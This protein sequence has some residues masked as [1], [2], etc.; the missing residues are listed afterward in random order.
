MS[1]SSLFMALSNKV[2]RC[3]VDLLFLLTKQIAA[4]TRIMPTALA[5]QNHHDCHKGDGPG[6]NLPGSVM[7]WIGGVTGQG[8][9]G[10]KAQVLRLRVR[11]LNSRWRWGR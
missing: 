9:Y 10:I 8:I 6:R 5:S 11:S 2:L 3:L 7:S 4:A 1:A